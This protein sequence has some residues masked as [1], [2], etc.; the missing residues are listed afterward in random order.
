M[1]VSLSIT[2][3]HRSYQLDDAYRQNTLIQTVKGWGWNGNLNMSYLSTKGWMYMLSANY[4]P[5]SYSLNGT[6]HRNP[7]LFLT[8]SKN[9]FNDR[10]ELGL[11]FVNSFVYCWNTRSNTYFR[12]M[13]QQSTQRQYAN[14]ITI[15]VAWNIGKQFRSRR[16]ASGI[17]NDDIV[18]KKG[19]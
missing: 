4:R 14:N 9:L 7:N 11:D 5:K 2:G 3:F 18:T 10:L 8:I 6:F 17:S 1:N 16:V 15:S 12:D 19:E 13:H